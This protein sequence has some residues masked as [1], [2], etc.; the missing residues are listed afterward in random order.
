LLAYSWPMRWK[1]RSAPERSTFTD[2]P[3]CLPSNS[4]ATFSPSARSTEVYHTTLPS[5][6]A[7]SISS[8][9]IFSAAGADWAELIQ[10]LAASAV[11]EPASTRRRVSFLVILRFLLSTPG[12]V[13]PANAATPVGRARCPAPAVRLLEVRSCRRAPPCSRAPHRET[14]GD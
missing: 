4:L 2:T 10:P 7:A 3:G 5:F 1:L 6:L 8:G 12:I 14:P 11:A 9:V 13:R